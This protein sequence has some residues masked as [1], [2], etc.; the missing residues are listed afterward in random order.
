MTVSAVTSGSARVPF[1]HQTN[2]LTLTLPSPSAA[3]RH[4]IVAITYRGAPAN[5]LR[6]LPN[7]Y[8]EWSAFSEN[9]PNRARE[10]LPM[11]DHP[12]DKAT[13]EFIVTA[14]SKY[15]IVANGLLQEEVALGDSRSRTHWKQ[16]VPI[17]SWLNAL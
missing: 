15:K 1:V 8:E 5:G 7:K 12:S 6:I 14:P 10:W 16:S 4:V 13:S 2:V 9:W 11:V 3:G 17:A